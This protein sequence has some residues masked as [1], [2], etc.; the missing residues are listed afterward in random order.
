VTD[1]AMTNSTLAEHES[2]PSPDQDA[3]SAE[4]VGSH[5][6]VDWQARSRIELVLPAVTELWSLVRLT[7][8]S[9]AARLDFALE[10]VEDLRLAIDELCTACA[11]GSETDSQMRLCFE[12]SSD[13][14]RVECVV[15]RV[16]D[17]DS[18]APESH[19]LPGD[20]DS[21]LLE[22]ASATALAEMIL[23]ELVD[24]HNIGPVN[25][26]VRQSYIEKRRSTKLS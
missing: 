4:M 1:E 15:D 10:D 16:V 7:I 21:D 3:R 26:G 5:T 8:S 2:H 9:I 13:P 12:T 19:R 22:G 23:S 6:F 17:I 24:V 18:G 25:A 11:A 14:I 20:W